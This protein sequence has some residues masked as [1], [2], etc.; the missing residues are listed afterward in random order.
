MRWVSIFPSQLLKIWTRLDTMLNILLIAD[1]VSKIISLVIFVCLAMW[2][3]RNPSHRRDGI[4]YNIPCK[5]CDR[6]YIGETARPIKERITEH[7]RDVRLR[8]T[9]NS[10]VAEHAW[11]NQHQPDWDGVQC[12]SQERHWYTRR[13]KEAINIRLNPNNFNRDNGSISPNFGCG[14]YAAMT[15]AVLPAN[16]GWFHSADGPSQRPVDWLSTVCVGQ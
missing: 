8:R 13:V 12:L 2:S 14:R 3:I 6:S 10:A 1:I 5:G 16:T 4:V 11:N 15:L 7:K 9:D